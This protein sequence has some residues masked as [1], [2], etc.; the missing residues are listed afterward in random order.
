MEHNH[1]VYLTPDNILKDCEQSGFENEG[2]SITDA[3]KEYIRQQTN[4]KQA[5]PSKSPRRKRSLSY[6]RLKG[7]H[8]CFDISLSLQCTRD[9]HKYGKK[10]PFVTPYFP[11]VYAIPI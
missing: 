11:F 4:E 9:Y 1:L 7:V 5:S 8:A 2:E 3:Q 10:T 6:K